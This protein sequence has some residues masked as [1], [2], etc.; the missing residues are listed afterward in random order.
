MSFESAVEDET[1]AFGTGEPVKASMSEVLIRL[2]GFASEEL[3][4]PA[5]G[6]LDDDRCDAGTDEWLAAGA[7]DAGWLPV[8]V[9]PELLG[10]HPATIMA[11]TAA[12][13]NTGA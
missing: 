5:T 3:P 2:Q 11:T 8:L 4:P 7:L 9:G 1:N 12:A 10:A 6:W 13:A